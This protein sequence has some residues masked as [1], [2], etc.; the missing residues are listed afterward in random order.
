VL[1]DLSLEFFDFGLEVG[2]LVRQGG[3]LLLLCKVLLL[4]GLNLGGEFVPCFVCAVEFGRKLRQFLQCVVS[5]D[6]VVGCEHP[7][8]TL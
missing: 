2:F 6:Q 7:G 3:D 1:L 4:E 5:K 8:P